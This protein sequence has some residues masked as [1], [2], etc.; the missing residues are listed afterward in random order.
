MLHPPYA[1]VATRRGV[2]IRK[3]TGHHEI[4]LMKIIGI[5]A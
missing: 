5:G 1:N 2:K 4:A 3:G